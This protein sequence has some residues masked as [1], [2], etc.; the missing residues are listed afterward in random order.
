MRAR[1]DAR[2]QHIRARGRAAAPGKATEVKASKLIVSRIP[3]ARLSYHEIAGRLPPAMSGHRRTGSRARATASSRANVPRISALRSRLRSSRLVPLA[4]HRLP[5]RGPGRQ[6]RLGDQPLRQGQLRR[7]RCGPWRARAPAA[8]AG[9][10]TGCRRP[11]SAAPARRA[12]SW[13]ES[14]CAAGQ[15]TLRQRGE[16]RLD[17]LVELEPAAAGE[18]QRAPHAALGQPLEQRPLLRLRRLHLGG[19]ERRLARRRADRSPASGSRS[20]RRQRERMVG[21]SRLGSDEISRNSARARRL[22]QRFQQRVGGVDVELVGGSRRSPR[23]RRPR[24]RSG[25]GTT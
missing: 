7:A 20:S 8:P 19:G 4:Q 13:S 5:Q 23:A 25:P 9:R 16:D 3:C 10:G 1:G 22:L 6:P 11:R 21:S 2:G 12:P 17:A 24:R 14:A 15:S 18:L